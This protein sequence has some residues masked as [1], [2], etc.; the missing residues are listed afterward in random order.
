MDQAF[1]GDNIRIRLR[2]VN[3]E[4][5]LP[6]FVLTSPTR[7]VKAV[8]A[9]KADLSIVETKNIICSGYSCVLHVHTLAEEVTLTVC[10]C[11]LEVSS[12]TDQIIQALLHYYDKKTRRKS[13]KPPQFAKVG[14]I[15]SA[16]IETS[17][18]ICIEKWDDYKMLGRFTLRDE[19]QSPVVSLRDDTLIA[20]IA[21]K[22]VAIGKVTK[23]IDKAEDMPDV[24]S[25]S[26]SNGA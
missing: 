14:M 22:T 24:G 10:H 1:C 16:L 21:G 12:E 23:L 18:P 7:P 19:G 25:L 3:D 4:D 8:T 9:F 5:V 26:V 11:F 6:G 13:K 17:A 15:V 20:R 2:G